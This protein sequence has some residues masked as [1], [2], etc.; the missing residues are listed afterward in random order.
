MDHWTIL[1]LNL[2]HKRVYKVQKSDETP[3]SCLTNLQ[4]I[5]MYI[6]LFCICHKVINIYFCLMCDLSIFLFRPM[7]FS[8]F[9]FSKFHNHFK[10]VFSD[11]D[12]KR[13]QLVKAT[14]YPSSI[15]NLVSW[16]IGQN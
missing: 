7:T 11:F 9:C 4:T 12:I 6:F 13:S 14:L 8:K 15:Y 10:I 2:T 16:S 5:S 1:A 3:S